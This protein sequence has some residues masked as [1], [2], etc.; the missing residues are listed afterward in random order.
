LVHNTNND[1]KP[2]LLETAI[3]IKY[4]HGDATAL[5]PGGNQIIVHICNDR[6]SWGDGFVM[7][8]SCRWIEPEACYHVYAESFNGKPM[9]LGAVQLVQVEDCSWI[10]NVIAQTKGFKH[11]DGWP[12][13]PIRYSVVCHVL[14]RIYRKATAMQEL[15][16]TCLGLVVAWRVEHGLRLN[17]LLMMG[18][19]TWSKLAC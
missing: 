11:P 17:K 9:E 12:V 10:V 16:F 19:R 7:D 18:W 1:I 2:N 8:V 13:P 3:P 5:P 4:V 14:M 15:Q 6:G